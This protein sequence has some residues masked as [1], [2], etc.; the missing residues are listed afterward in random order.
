[1]YAEETFVNIYLTCFRLIYKCYSFF[2]IFQD[3]KIDLHKYFSKFGEVSDV[4]IPKPFRAFAF[5]T[6]MDAEIAQSL[7]GEDHIIKGT[8]VH[9]SSATPKSFGKYED[10]S[11]GGRERDGRRD[12]DRGDY[13]RLRRRG[14]NN[15]TVRNE[16]AMDRSIL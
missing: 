15:T 14:D 8:S 13:D 12:R 2:R 4:F 5:V 16:T 7:C 10:Q 11:Q 3:D 1:M 6:F 9:V